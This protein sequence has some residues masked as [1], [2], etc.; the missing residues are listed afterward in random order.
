MMW[1]V[2]LAMAVGLVVGFV[3]DRQVNRAEEHKRDGG[4]NLVSGREDSIR[5]TASGRRESADAKLAGRSL[6]DR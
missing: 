2:F 3:A 6:F 4:R 1:K 5:A